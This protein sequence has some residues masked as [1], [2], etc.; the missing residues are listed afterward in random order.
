MSNKK[1][2][3]VFDKGTMQTLG[4]V[5]KGTSATFTIQDVIKK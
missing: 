2:V 4:E 1:K 5:P 3:V